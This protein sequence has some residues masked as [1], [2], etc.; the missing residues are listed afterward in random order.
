[1]IWD[2]ATEAGEIIVSKDQDFADRARRQARRGT[3][4]LW[5]RTGNGATSELVKLLDPLLEQIE[6]RILL[7]DRLIEVRRTTSRNARLL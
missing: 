2:T 6:V 1:M 4:V 3:A 5:L 7:G